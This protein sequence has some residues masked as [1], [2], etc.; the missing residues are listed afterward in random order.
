VKYAPDDTI[1]TCHYC[2]TELEVGH[3][4][5]EMLEERDSIEPPPRSHRKPEGTKAGC[6]VFL[7]MFGLCAAIF[8]GI[9]YY[10]VYVEPWQWDGHKSFSC[11]DG[12]G[13][14]T[15]IQATGNFEARG[16]CNVELIAPQLE[17]SIT[18]SDHATV[19]VV[20]GRVH[21]KNGTGV[22]AKGFAK[23]ILEGTTVDASEAVRAKDAASVESR[24]AIILG[25]VNL[26]SPR[27]VT[28][29]GWPATTSTSKRK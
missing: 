7:G 26:D 27:N 10:D 6:F 21:V 17:A 22:T 24:G 8:G 28:G 15:K 16:N 2:G 9:Y 25:A 4:K 14:I 3:P 1:V 12:T 11:N 13:T 5:R 29:A 23:V 20:G 18:A 19:H